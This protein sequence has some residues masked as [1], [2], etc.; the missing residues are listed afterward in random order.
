VN[1]VAWGAPLYPLDLLYQV[2][3]GEWVAHQLRVRIG[4]PIPDRLVGQG[5]TLLQVGDDA[6]HHL[7]DFVG[8]VRCADHPERAVER[9]V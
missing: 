6:P 3:L 9:E 8:G 2:R 7:A 4:L 5:H 1:G